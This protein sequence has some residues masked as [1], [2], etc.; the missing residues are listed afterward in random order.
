MESQMKP[1]VIQDLWP[2]IKNFEK[3]QKIGTVVYAF[4]KSKILPPPIQR[5]QT[6]L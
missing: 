4:I 5:L 1:L 2:N 3:L 6:N